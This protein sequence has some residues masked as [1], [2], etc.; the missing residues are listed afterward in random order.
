MNLSKNMKNFP[1]TRHYKI[2]TWVFFVKNGLIR[3]VNVNF[4]NFGTYVPCGKLRVKAVR[5]SS[6]EIQLWQNSS[7]WISSEAQKFFL[8][9]IYSM[10]ENIGIQ[11]S[12][13][14]LFQCWKIPFENFPINEE[15]FSIFLKNLL[16]FLL[17]WRFFE[18]F[19]ESIF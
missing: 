18:F 4:K 2:I 19:S 8:I 3:T 14:V 1:F 9:S 10:A 13:K 16:I 12:Q 7:R 17:F 6:I 15:I 5:A 11:W